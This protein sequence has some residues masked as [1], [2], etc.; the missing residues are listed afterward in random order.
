MTRFTLNFYGA[1]MLLAVVLAPSLVSAGA[2]ELS[3]N[4]K[5][6]PMTKVKASG[7]E[8]S[9]TGFNLK[10]WQPAIVPGTVLTNMLERA[11][12]RIHSTE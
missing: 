12:C 10:K 4:W 1:L 9:A 3:K 11:K 7:E 6:A 2:V 5:S 8:I